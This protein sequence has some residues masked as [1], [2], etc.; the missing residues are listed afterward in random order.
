MPLRKFRISGI[1]ID[2]K[3][4]K[5]APGLLVEVWDRDDPR[6]VVFGASMTDEQGEYLIAATVD[7]PD[8]VATPISSVLTVFQGAERRPVAGQTFVANLLTFEGR[9]ILEMTADDEA[10]LQDKVTV[11]QILNVINFVRQSDFRGFLQEGKDRTSAAVDLA[12]DVVKNAVFGMGL[13][14]IRPPEIRNKDIVHQ[15]PATARARL[16]AQG[17]AINEVKP[18]RKNAESLATITS[19]PV[20]LKRGDKV[21]IYEEG[22]VVK[23][24]AVVR[25]DNASIDAAAVTQLGSDLKSLRHDLDGRV[26]DVNRLN[27]D[28]SARAAEIEELRAKLEQRDATIASLNSEL[29]NVRK[30]HDSLAAQVRPERLAAI[31]DTLKKIQ[32]RLPR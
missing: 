25:P 11:P 31:E 2:A 17:V 15:D 10:L 20:N 5:G 24:Y 29:A 26:S 3:T 1:V 12:F 27:Q 30:A 13:T 19:L 9:A 14:P 18:Y 4:R 23:A 8:V 7:L 28:A 32:D 22:G 21:D 16:A 6:H